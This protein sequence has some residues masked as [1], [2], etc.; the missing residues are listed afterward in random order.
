MDSRANL[1]CMALPPPHGDTH[2]CRGSPASSAPSPSRSDAHPAAQP[3][4]PLPPPAGPLPPPRPPTRHSGTAGAPPCEPP[5]GAPPHHDAAD[6]GGGG[7]AADKLPHHEAADAA[8]VA[9]DA[10]LAP[11]SLGAGGGGGGGGACTAA[12]A[13]SLWGLGVQPRISSS[14]VAASLNQGVPVAEAV[15]PVAY[16]VPVVADIVL[17]L[18]PPPVAAVGS[19]PCWP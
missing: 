9:A 5:C 12:S 15:P 18:P 2:N 8:P 16:D 13:V 6:P 7:A 17:A 3:Q 19:R 10:A 14:S 11:L 4:P 1:T